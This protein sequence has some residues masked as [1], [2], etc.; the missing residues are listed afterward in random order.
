MSHALRISFV[1]YD[2]DHEQD[3]YRVQH[4]TTHSAR[5]TNPRG[6]TDESTQYL[7]LS[8]HV[9]DT[10]F[11]L[12]DL[13]AYGGGILLFFQRALDCLMIS[14]LSVSTLPGIVILV[15]LMKRRYE[16]N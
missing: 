16:R 7:R 6:W 1:L 5:G 3:L 8:E 9:G 10:Y 14:L 15:A 4:A 11:F 12:P 2:D 13:T